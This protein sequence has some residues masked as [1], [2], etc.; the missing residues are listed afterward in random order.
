MPIQQWDQYV[1]D[2]S[3][4]I[5]KTD[6]ATSASSSSAP[7]RWDGSRKTN[8][9]DVVAALLKE[10]S[11]GFGQRGSFQKDFAILVWLDFSLPCDFKFLMIV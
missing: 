7:S 8:S 10:K 4:S 1:K 2:L 3:K 11:S 5:N 6:R 9:A